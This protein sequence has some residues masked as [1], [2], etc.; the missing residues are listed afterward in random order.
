MLCVTYLNY[1]PSNINPECMGDTLSGSD[2]SRLVDP[3]PDPLPD[4][5]G[6]VCYDWITS[7][8]IYLHVSISHIF[9]R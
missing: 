7:L 2:Q 4:R 6:K 9:L 5:S 1:Y 8:I 3:C